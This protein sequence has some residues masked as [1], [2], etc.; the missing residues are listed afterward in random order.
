[1]GCAWLT[2]KAF[3]NREFRAVLVE[4]F[5]ADPG[6]I[7]PARLDA[8]RRRVIQALVRGMPQ[9]EAARVFGVSRQ[10]VRGDPGSRR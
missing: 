4:R 7:T 3:G 5:D 10:S 8:L 6:E 2:F 1:M 9:A